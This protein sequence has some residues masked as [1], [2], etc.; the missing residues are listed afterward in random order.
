LQLSAANAR[1]LARGLWHAEFMTSSLSTVRIPSRALLVAG[2][3]ELARQVEQ[4][5]RRLGC[6]IVEVAGD[7]VEARKRC[8]R[9]APEVVLIDLRLRD[10]AALAIAGEL[11]EQLNVPV[12]LLG[13]TQAALPDGALEHASG[14]VDL[15]LSAAGLQ[16][17][18][19]FALRR[20]EPQR[21]AAQPPGGHLSAE[22]LASMAHE[23]RAPLQGVVGFAAFLREGKAGAVSET[24]QQYLDYIGNGADHVLQVVNDVL[25]LTATDSDS[26][27]V[28]TEAVD[29]EQ[30]AREV[31]QVLQLIAIRRRIGVEVQVDEQLGH[32][33]SDVTKLKQVLYNFVSNAL[34]FT[35][36][37]GRIAVSLRREGPD[38]FCIE[39]A[40]TG[41]GIAPELLPELFERGPRRTD[42][43]A[44]LGLSITKR[45][46]TALG[47]TVAAHNRAEGGSVFSARLPIA[48][49]VANLA[50]QDILL[51]DKR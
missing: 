17:S 41:V 8:A 31:L 18:L 51:S 38:T 27:R 11:S 37:G 35:P 44:G 48:P 28:R 50:I 16:R 30:V 20:S 5:M 13:D 15:P 36:A 45:I 9:L 40:D 23:L 49:S 7:R 32:V 4:H 3:T 1:P 43:S 6:E 19:A 26:L 24:Q 42:G 33:V 22:L 21:R 12:L 25:D 34:K 2:D 10:R 39:V 46:V 47:G 14:W 29:P